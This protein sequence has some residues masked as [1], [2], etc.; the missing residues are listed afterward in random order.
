M[1]YK[2]NTNDTFCLIPSLHSHTSLHESIASPYLSI[3][4]FIDLYICTYYVHIYAYVYIMHI[5]Y[6]VYKL[7]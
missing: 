5:K 6:I 4:L 1:K 3:Y 7:C 2:W